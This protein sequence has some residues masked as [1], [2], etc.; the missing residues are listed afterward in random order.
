MDVYSNT[1]R[2]LNRYTT[3]LTC[4]REERGVICSVDKIQPG[5]IRITSTARKAP[6]APIPN[7]FL[8]VLRK[9]G[10][11]WLWEHTRV[12]G[13]MEW[14][15]EAIQDGSLV[16]VTDSSYIRQLHLNLFLAAFVLECTKGNGKIIRSFSE[17]TLA[18]NAYRGELLGL[19]AIHLLL[20]S[21]NRVHNTLVGSVEVVSDCLGALKW[22]VHLPPY[23]IPLHC[24]HLDILKNILVNCPN[25]T[26]TLYYLHMKAHQDG[27][28]AFNKLS[29]KLQL[30]CIC[31]HP[32]K[33]RIS[34]SAQ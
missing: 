25:P 5:V 19:M 12:E 10:C 11:T 15:L 24:K 13:G 16:A 14:I 23:W 3:T 2:K 4:P 33:Q 1:A 8:A 27:N 31:N 29:W 9:W 20:V 6:T 17:Y 21:V 30:N 18:A 32:A 26:F 28:V 22:E 7:S 34:E